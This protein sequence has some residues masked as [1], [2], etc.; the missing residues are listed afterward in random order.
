MVTGSLVGAVTTTQ[1]TTFST[2]SA[3]AIFYTGAVVDVIPGDTITFINGAAS[4]FGT[5]T[6]FIDV[7]ESLNDTGTTCVCRLTGL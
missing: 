2:S 7:T 1:L 5:A 3:P 6:G 4:N